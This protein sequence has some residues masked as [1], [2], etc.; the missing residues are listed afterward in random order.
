MDKIIFKISNLWE[1]S[2]P[3]FNNKSTPL[4]KNV[5]NVMLSISEWRFLLK[6]RKITDF[7]LI[8]LLLLKIFTKNSFSF[9]RIKI[10]KYFKLKEYKYN[11]K[12]SV[13]LSY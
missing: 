12:N 13:F 9:F 8:L 4:K 1:M 3:H 5:N 10:D 11:L 2:T 7:I 6:K